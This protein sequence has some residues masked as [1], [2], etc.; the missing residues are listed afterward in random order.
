MT[1]I[2]PKTKTLMGILGLVSTI[3]FAASVYFY[4]RAHILQSE[5]ANLSNGTQLEPGLPIS[6]MV[7]ILITIVLGF[8][9]LSL[10]A[11][12]REGVRKATS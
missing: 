11:K 3:L 7:R 12:G 9:S 8:V 10:I 5:A 1:Q 2:A 6:V 4:Y